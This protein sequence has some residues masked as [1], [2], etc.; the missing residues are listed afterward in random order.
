MVKTLGVVGGGVVGHATARS[1]MEHTEVRVY[2]VVAARR[3]HGMVETLECDLIFLCLPT[4]QDGNGD[5]DV[6]AVE[7]FC[8]LLSDSK[9][10]GNYVLKSTVPIGTTRR[11]AREHGLANLVHS[12]EF[13]TARCAVTDA[14]LPARNIIG[15]PYR[16]RM[17]DAGH[18]LRELY[19]ER[20]PGVSIYVMS[21]DESEAVKLAQ[22][23]FFAVK[24]AYWNEIYRMCRRDGLDWGRV[25]EAV[26][27]D[28]RIAHA[29]TSVPGQGGLTG[30]GGACLPS[31]FT[32]RAKDGRLIPIETATVGIEAYSTDCKCRVVEYKKVAAVTSRRYTGDLINLEVGG[33]V[34]SCTPDHLMPV[35]RNGDLVVVRAV[36]ILPTDRLMTY[37]DG[38]HQ[39]PELRE[40]QPEALQAAG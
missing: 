1:F 3:T 33:S 25:R 29:H 20:F 36:D 34:F 15:S 17:S 16:D 19:L 12:P 27:A 13:L 10:D 40:A 28:G 7:D 18:L 39:V 37:D 23:G 9:P 24:V 26:L 35:R 14:Q 30:F 32:L 31:G 22:N 11:L 5:C 38:K 4:P 6:S 8:T 21:S 2:D